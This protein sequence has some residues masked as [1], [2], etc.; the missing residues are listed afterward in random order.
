M[1]GQQADVSSTFL[2]D[3]HD[4]LLSK[5]PICK[6]YQGKDGATHVALLT[7]ID[8]IVLSLR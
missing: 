8:S 3:D 7:F 5:S 2:S 6:S 4:L 1:A